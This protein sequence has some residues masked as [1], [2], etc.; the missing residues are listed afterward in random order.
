MKEQEPKQVKTQPVKA[1]IEPK[2]APAPVYD[3]AEIA[4][5]APRLFG[6]NSDLATA[7]LAYNKIARCSLNQ[8]KQIIKDFAERKVK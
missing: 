7:A 6:Y 2:P 5:N 4:A 1:A 3:A 8:A